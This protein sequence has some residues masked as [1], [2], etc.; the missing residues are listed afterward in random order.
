MEKN[1]KIIA[2]I[3][4]V[5]ILVV[6]GVGTILLAG[7]RTDGNKVVYWTVVAPGEQ[8]NALKAGI[9]DGAIG[10]EPYTSSALIDGT[11]NAVKWS[12]DVWPNHPCCVLVVSK[13]FVNNNATNQ[14]L[15]ARIVKVQI[16]ANEWLTKTIQ[17]GS[18]ANFTALLQTGAAFANV[19]T[20]VIQ[21]AVLNGHTKFVSGISEGAKTGL[22]NFTRSLASLGQITGLGGY[23]KV[24][25]F[26]NGT[27]NATYLQRASEI[28]E[29]ATILNPSTPVRMMYLTGDI[30]QFARVIAM[31][32]SLWGGKTLFERY[33]VAVNYKAPSPVG[34]PIMDAIQAGQVD[35][36]YVGCVPVIL[37]RINVPT[38]IEIVSVLNLEG[39]AIIAKAPMHT[40]DDLNGKLIATPGPTSIQHFLLLYYATALGYTVKLKG[41]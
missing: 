18:G 7:G 24:T 6:A 21:E 34:G 11:A 20:S 17:E 23:S 19:N 40:F 16:V 39:S 37:K 35:V 25:D 14:D 38:Y 4:V 26:V 33:G 32:T 15:V 13:N 30:H 22:A 10:W 28:N 27:I 41:T 2:V 9:V 1:T 29:S 5:A 36:G 31:N 12:G 3:A 8:K